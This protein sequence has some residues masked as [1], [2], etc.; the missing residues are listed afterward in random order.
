[1]RKKRSFYTADTVFYWI[2]LY[3][4]ALWRFQILNGFFCKHFNFH[5]RGD[6]KC[7]LHV[8]VGLWFSNRN[9]WKVPRRV[10]RSIDRG[11]QRKSAAPHR[12]E[13]A[14]A[15]AWRFSG[16]IPGKRPRGLR[17]LINSLKQINKTAFNNKSEVDLQQ[18][19]TES[20]RT[21]M[22]LRFYPDSIQNQTNNAFEWKGN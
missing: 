16:H 22:C 14:E 20:F 11:A 9:R 21:E 2:F 4:V 8:S 15:D 12:K 3:V 10:R 18:C 6:F 7:A 5:F 19:Q 13:F 1:M 17:T